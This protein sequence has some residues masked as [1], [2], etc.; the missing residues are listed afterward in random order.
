[1][2]CFPALEDVPEQVVEFVRRTVELPEDGDPTI[3]I[4]RRPAPPDRTKALAENQK[5]RRDLDGAD[6]TQ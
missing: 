1:M 2:G 5:L 4:E 3:G 6:E